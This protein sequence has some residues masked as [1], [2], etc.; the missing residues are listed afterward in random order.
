M[1]RLGLSAGTR[2]SYSATQFLDLAVFRD[3]LNPAFLMPTELYYVDNITIVPL[4]KP[5]NFLSVSICTQSW[6]VPQ[7]TDTKLA[8]REL[9]CQVGS[10][11]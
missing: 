7:P 8:G 11:S 2:D 10:P 6:A 3:S 1:A 9:V 4:K 5:T